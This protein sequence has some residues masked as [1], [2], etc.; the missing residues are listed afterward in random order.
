M[1]NNSYVLGLFGGTYDSSSAVTN[2][3]LGQ[4]AKKQPTPPWST[5]VAPPKADAM[6]RAALGGRRFINEDAAQLDVKSASADYRKLFALYQG[7]DTLT[8]LTNRAGTKGVS[9]LE[10]AQ[11]NK[12]FSAG[13]SEI[14]A[15]LSSADFDGVRMAQG[16]AA[17]ISK[18]GAGVPRDSAVS[19]TAPIHEGSPDTVSPAFAGDVAFDITI[20]TT[21]ETKTVAVDLTDMGATPRTLTAVLD[22]INGK[23]EAAGVA[24]R[25]GREQVKAEPKTVTVNGKPVTLPAGADKWALVVRGDSTE[26]VGFAAAARADAVYVVQGAGTAGGHQLLKFQSDTGGAPPAAVARPGETH[27]VE[28]RAGQTALPPGVETVR[29]SAAGPDG[30]LWLVA[31]VDAG[32]A[33]QPIK[34]Q[35]DVALIKLDSA[36]RVVSTRAL[37]AASTA[38]GYAIAIDANGRVAVAGSVTGALESGKSGELAAVADSFV[39]VFDADGA[40]VWTQRRGARAADEAT[41]VSFGPNGTVYVG[42]R[43]QGSIPG[44]VGQG[45]WDGYVQAFSESQ[46]HI[47]A[48]VVATAAGVAQFGTAAE[49]GVGAIAV[50]GAN[51]Y[52]AGVEDGRFVVRHF[53][54][55][56]AGKPTLATTRD[57]GQASGEIAGLSVSGGRVI[58]TGTTRNDAL[59]IGAVNTAHHGGTDAFV[60]VMEGDLTAS[61]NDRL[62]YVGAAGDDTAADVKVVGGKVWVSGVSDRALGAKDTDPTQAYLARLDADT[63]AVEWRRDWQGNSEQAVPLTLAVAANGASVLDRLG[64]PQGEIDQSQSKLLTVA[65][66]VRTGDRFYVSPADGGRRIAVTLDARDTLQTLARKIEQASNRKLKVTIATDSGVAGKQGDTPLAV[67]GGFQRLSITARDGKTGAILT[68]GE[69]GRDALAGLGLSQGYVGPTSGDGTLRTFGLDLPRN[70][71][72]ND[73]TAVKASGER[74]QAAMK[75]VRDAYRALAPATTLPGAGGPVPAYLT[76]QLANYQAALARLGG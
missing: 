46:A 1:I 38:S 76:A 11:L 33:N 47:F 75:A 17:S 57:L 63:G 48:P 31:D 42:G 39:T 3:A 54:L 2:A 20:R 40:E 14:G 58:L 59:D 62:T 30:S 73:A 16:V 24:T 10:M 13:L 37:G 12:R 5:S 64:L 32:P 71:T 8:A 29:A 4:A 74:L 53:T 15:W 68:A 26:T 25:I 51:L 27:W 7:L 28:G 56:G 72:L 60:A 61:A 45:G 49:D 18:T 66:S 55:D 35:K 67:M 50:D 44:A 22:H 34:G 36:G 19:V 65:T 9:S 69:P 43:S 21:L 23:L 70:L 6:V 52:S 41:S